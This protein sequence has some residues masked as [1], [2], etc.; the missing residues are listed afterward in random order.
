MRQR[1]GGG[2]IRRE[3]GGQGGLEPG[4]GI[5]RGGEGGLAG[6]PLLPGGVPAWCSSRGPHVRKLAIMMTNPCLMWPHYI[7]YELKLRTQ[8]LRSL[9]LLQLGQG[10]SLYKGGGRGNE[11]WPKFISPFVNFTFSHFEI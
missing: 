7:S 9:R 8:L 4:G 11:K 1:G 3:E 6:T 10:R 2:G 5:K